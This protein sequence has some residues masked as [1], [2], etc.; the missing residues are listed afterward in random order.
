MILWPRSDHLIITSMTTR[1]SS[2]SYKPTNARARLDTLVGL[3]RH[4]T[5]RD[6]PRNVRQRVVRGGP[7]QGSLRGLL[8]GPLARGMTKRE[9][10]TGF[11]CARIVWVFI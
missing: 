10:D 3:H 4:E 5:R 8:R 11:Y 6:K 2:K 7:D 1:P 9:R